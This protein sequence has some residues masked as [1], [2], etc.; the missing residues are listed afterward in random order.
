MRRVAYAQKLYRDPE[1]LRRHFLALSPEDHKAINR[2]IRD[3]KKFTRVQMP[4]T[5]LPKLKTK[6]PIK[7]PVSMLFSM[8]PAMPRM[9]YYQN[10]SAAEF[11]DQFN[12]PQIRNLPQ[13]T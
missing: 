8:L 5:D 3:I 1:Q 11:G 10:L 12:H 4:V 6:H 7:F 9:K 2:L 13:K